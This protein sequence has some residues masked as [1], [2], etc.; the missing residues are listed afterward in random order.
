MVFLPALYLIAR[1]INEIN[2][3]ISNLSFSYFY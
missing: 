2:K 3:R 1:K